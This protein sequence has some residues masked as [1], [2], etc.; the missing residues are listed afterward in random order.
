MCI[1]SHCITLQL[2]SYCWYLLVPHDIYMSEA[3]GRSLGPVPG[4]WVG[5]L[6]PIGQQT[7]C[8]RDPLCLEAADP[9]GNP[10]IFNGTIQK[11]GDWSI[12]L[13]GNLWF[14]LTSQNPI[15]LKGFKVKDPIHVHSLEIGKICGAFTSEGLSN[16]VK[17]YSTASDGEQSFLDGPCSLGNP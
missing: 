10:A 6:D 16:H 12:N 11:W 15:A 4:G 8:A 7:D 13:W 5:T 9:W 17:S 14:W 1:Y 3:P 2:Y